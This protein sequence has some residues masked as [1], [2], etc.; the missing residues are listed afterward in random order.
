[1][2]K[3]VRLGGLRAEDQRARARRRQEPCCHLPNHH[4]WM[5]FPHNDIRDGTTIGRRAESIADIEGTDTV[6]SSGIAARSSE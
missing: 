5:S 2:G 4:L 3:R 6:R 1:M